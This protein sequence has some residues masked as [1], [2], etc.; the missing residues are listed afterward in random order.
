MHQ[1]PLLVVP[2]LQIKSL[3]LDHMTWYQDGNPSNGHRLCWPEL[4]PYHYRDMSVKASPNN[5]SLDCL[6]R[7]LFRHHQI[8]A[9]QSLCGGNPPVV[10]SLLKW[11]TSCCTNSLVD[12]DLRCHD[13]MPLWRH[14]VSVFSVQR[15][16]GAGSANGS[17]CRSLLADLR[18]GGV[19]RRARHC[20]DRAVRHQGAIR[21]QG[22]LL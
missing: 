17:V 2:F 20:R 4:A 22:I 3:Q 10:Y 12:D 19:R 21:W 16:P 18:H 15:V 11:W 8:D 13:V 9:L 6:F 5:R 1:D 7:R 14:A